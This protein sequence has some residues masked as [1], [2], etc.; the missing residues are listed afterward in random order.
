[1]KYILYA[2]LALAAL[3][4]GSRLLYVA[5]FPV[6]TFD[7]LVNTAYDAQDKTLNADNAIY[8]YEWF[9]QQFEDIKALKAK[10]QIA[11]QSVVDFNAAAGPR[12]EWTFED[13]T[14][15]ARLGAIAQG[16]RSQLEDVIATYNARGKM[17]NRT[18]FKDSIVPSFIDSM[19][20]IKQ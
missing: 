18:L 11:D 16:L 1:M 7:K 6:N 14:E 19:T 4:I 10:V 8:N 3:G 17:A 15:A 20:F 9:K 13:K 5:F 2:L 12:T